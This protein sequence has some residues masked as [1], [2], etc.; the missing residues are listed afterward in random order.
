[1]TVWWVPIVTFVGGS[2]V[3]LGVEYLRTR[4]AREDRRL[5]AAERNEDRVEER[6]ARSAE[7]AELRRE[8][9]NARQRAALIEL[10]ERLSDWM[11]VCGQSEMLAVE[12]WAAAGK[13]TGE[14]V[15]IL[16]TSPE[17]SETLNGFQRRVLV[18][19][20]RIN[21]ATIRSI[22]VDLNDG[23]VRWG[24]AQT[25]LAGVTAQTDMGGCFRN[26][27]ERIGQLLR[28]IPN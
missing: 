1:M 26:V 14:F 4:Q 12:A 15:P 7:R 22:L 8:E 5:D 16:S 11:R 19:S 2:A 6:N 21:D 10:Q 18:L 24:M 13:P 17:L 9:H 27:N 20:E 25:M 3:T 28:E 23:Y